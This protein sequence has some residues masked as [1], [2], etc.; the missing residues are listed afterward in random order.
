MPETLPAVTED[1]ST[2]PYHIGI[3]PELIIYLIETEG[4]TQADCARRL[5]CHQST[6]TRHLQNVGYVPGYLKLVNNAEVSIL[7]QTT[8][9]ILNRIAMY[10]HKKTSFRDLVVSYGVLTDKY[11]LLTGQPTENITYVD[12][13]KQKEVMESR[14]S[15]FE[16]KYNITA[17]MISLD[18][19]S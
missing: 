13:L 5:K 3:T 14:L 2:S 9:K 10:D 15:S 19:D 1:N 7:K 8:Q 12:A 17:D 6:I 11:Q 16:D 4:L 18:E